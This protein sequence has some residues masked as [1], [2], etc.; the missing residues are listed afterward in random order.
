MCQCINK[1]KM[2]AMSEDQGMTKQEKG[3]NVYKPIF[4]VFIQE[5]QL[6]EQRKKK[7]CG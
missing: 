6:L 1:E 4:C 2:R 5:G 3:S 7:L